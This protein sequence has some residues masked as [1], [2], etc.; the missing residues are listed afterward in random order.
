MGAIAMLVTEPDEED[1][2]LDQG[3]LLE[4]ERYL[5]GR[6]AQVIYAGGQSPLNP[7]YWGLYGGSEFAGILGTHVRF[8]RRRRTGRLRGGGQYRPA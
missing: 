3:L 1:P 5:R 7:F 6:G 4:A 2:E 8:L